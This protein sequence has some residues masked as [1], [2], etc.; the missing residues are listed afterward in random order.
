MCAIFGILGEYDEHTAKNALATLTHRGPDFC[1]VV[2]RQN[3]FFAHQLL[4]IMDTTSPTNQPLIHKKI[5]LSFNG[6]IYNFKELQA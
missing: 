5:L 4:S 6:E 2:Q 1:G 3:L